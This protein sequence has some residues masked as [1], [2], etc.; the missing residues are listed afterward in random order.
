MGQSVGKRTQDARHGQP[1]VARAQPFFLRVVDALRR[2]LR[3][4]RISRDAFFRRQRD[5]VRTAAD[6]VLQPF[7]FKRRHWQRRLPS[8]IRGFF[9]DPYDRESPR[10]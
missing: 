7:A 3:D 8:R 5:P 6:L 10:R 9:L 1:T 2:V 4:N